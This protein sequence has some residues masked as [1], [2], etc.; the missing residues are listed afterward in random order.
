MSITVSSISSVYAMSREQFRD[1]KHRK[2]QESTDKGPKYD[3]FQDSR[4]HS[5][6]HLIDEN[7]NKPINALL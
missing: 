5:K 6:A 3:G 2:N 4:N 7:L 1:H